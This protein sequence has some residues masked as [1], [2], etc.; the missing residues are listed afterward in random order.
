M[1]NDL[2]AAK[3]KAEATYNSAADLFDAG[4]NAFWSRHGRGT[5]ERLNLTLGASVLDVGCGT[6]ASAIP[7]AERIGP[8]GRVIAVDLAENMLSRARARAQ[9]QGLAN[10]EFRRGDMTD[11]GF[12]DMHFDAVISVFSVF[13]VP[14]MERQVAELWRMLRP[15]GLFAVTSWTPRFLEPCVGPFWD[16]VERRRPELR[17]VCNPWER[18]GSAPALREVLQAGG[19]KNIE[20]EERRDWQS[21]ADP[22]DW[23]TVVLGSGLCWTVDQLSPEDAEELHQESV[24]WVADNQIISFDTSVLFARAQKPQA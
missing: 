24:R 23:W 12:P 6:G 9:D 1:Q 8:R 10:V 18:I 17:R 22:E 15:G 14:D 19:A 3:A 20:V 16:E 11:L 7:A 13:F 4:S 5:V 21:L 2:E